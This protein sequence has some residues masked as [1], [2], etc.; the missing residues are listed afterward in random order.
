MRRGRRRAMSCV[1]GAVVKRRE[2]SVS[3]CGA[4]RLASRKGEAGRS[5]ADNHDSFG[6]DSAH[7][8]GGA[9][10]ELF[11]GVVVSDA[12]LLLTSCREGGKNWAR[13]VAFDYGMVFEFCTTPHRATGE[14]AHSMDVFGKRRRLGGSGRCYRRDREG[15]GDNN[16]TAHVADI[17]P[18]GETVRVC[19]ISK[20][21][22]DRRCGGHLG[23]RVK[24]MKGE[25]VPLRP[26]EVHTVGVPVPI[27]RRSWR[28]CAALRADQELTIGIG[29]Q[30]RG[31]GAHVARNSCSSED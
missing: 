16:P 17:T 1:R 10:W 3:R 18:S 9:R 14:N 11:F 25:V 2:Q 30:D 22:N 29:V 26:T 31:V 21:R 19:L 6:F 8:F 15:S 20:I 28:D 27:T 13:G 23:R 4:R 5:G 12:A 24:G 7:G